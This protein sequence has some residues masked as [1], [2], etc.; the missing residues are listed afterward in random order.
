MGVEEHTWKK[1]LTMNTCRP[2]MHI[3]SKLSMTLK[4]NMRLSV[5]RTVLK[6]RFSLVR[7]Y[8]WLRVTVESWPDSLKMDSSSADVC[9]GDVPCLEGIDA[10]ASFSTCIDRAA[11]VSNL[12]T[13]PIVASIFAPRGCA[14]RRLDPEGEEHVQRSRN[15]QT[16]LRMCSSGY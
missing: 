3:I 10:R 2:A 16:S 7:K 8:F 12:K 9:S 5:L 15:L 4:L 6:F 14:I 13:H 1:N 11:Q